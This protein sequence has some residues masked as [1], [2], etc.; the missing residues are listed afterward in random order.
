M[1][2]NK[3][4]QPELFSSCISNLSPKERVIF[5]CLAKGTALKEIAAEL[6]IS[7]KTVSTYR[8][9]ILEKLKLDSNAS[10]VKFALLNNL[11]K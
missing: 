3:L 9:R 8:A 1:L 5:F 6:S 10:L 4:S 7:A 11:I 2:I